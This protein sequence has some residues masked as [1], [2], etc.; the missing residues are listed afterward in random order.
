MVSARSNLA[1]WKSSERSSFYPFEP[2]PE[3]DGAATTHQ[4][5]PGHLGGKAIALRCQS[6][7]TKPETSFAAVSDAEGCTTGD[8]A[9]SIRALQRE[10]IGRRL[11]QLHILP[12]C[13]IFKS[14]C[15]TNIYS[16][17]EQREKKKETIRAEAGE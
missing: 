14:P 7:I 13:C 9:A 10:R 3:T 12:F 4:E 17:R 1:A 16:E 5:L 11:D 8:G 6:H 15:N 2:T